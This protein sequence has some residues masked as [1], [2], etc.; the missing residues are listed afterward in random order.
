MTAK[1]LELKEKKELESKSEKTYSCKVYMPHV[2][3]YENQHEIILEADMPGVDKKDVQVRLENNVLSIDAKIRPEEY[4][5]MR[6]LYSEYN[7]GH[8]YRDFQIGELVE[9]NKINATVDN[10]VLVVTLPKVE[11]ARPR[12]ITVK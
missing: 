8:Y 5:G 1:E 3:I 9:Q 6:A 10:G 2:D 11:Q 4:E 12:L 7:I